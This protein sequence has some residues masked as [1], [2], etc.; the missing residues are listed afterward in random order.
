M[1]KT[2]IRAQRVAQILYRQLVE[3]FRVDITNEEIKGVIL[4]YVDLSPDLKN[5]KIYF[6]LPQGQECTSKLTASLQK[7]S[8]FLRKKIAEKLELRV[9][10]RLS[11][12]YDKVQ[13]NRLRVNELLG[14]LK[15]A[16]A[17]DESASELGFSEV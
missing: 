5:A 16:D 11:F 3:C 14:S 10:P 15:Y 1:I 12:H 7:A 4:S 8:H 17:L 13:E 6:T 9:T 2:S